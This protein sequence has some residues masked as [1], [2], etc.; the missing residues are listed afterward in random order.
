MVALSRDTVQMCIVPEGKL[1]AKVRGETCPPVC[2][3][4][5][6]K[7][8]RTLVHGFGANRT[9]TGDSRKSCLAHLL[10]VCFVWP[11]NNSSFCP[12]N[13][14]FFCLPRDRKPTPRIRWPALRA[15][16]G[17]RARGS[18]E[19]PA[20]PSLL[21]LA[22]CAGGG[23]IAGLQKVILPLDVQ[24]IA[25]KDWSTRCEA[26]APIKQCMYIPPAVSR[27]LCLLFPR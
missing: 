27:L 17:A 8:A 9:N 4:I 16:A 6:S 19:C 11:V 2:L 3:P 5:A 1:G 22:P 18:D 12:K 15:V 23:K 7:R 10:N 21:R 24:K 25:T 14:S 13:A 20:L 26:V